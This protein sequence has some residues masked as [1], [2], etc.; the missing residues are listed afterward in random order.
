MEGALF[1]TGKNDWET[2]QD[3]FD[4]W[5][6]LF[7]FTIDVCATEANHKCDRYYSPA[8]NGLTKDWQFEVVWCNPPYSAKEQ[9][10]WV[11]KCWEEGQ[12]SKTIVVALLPARTDT[13][14]FH[15][16]IYHQINSE[17]L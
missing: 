15:N 3:F 6:N 13:K 7:H 1:S 10:L 2:P 16:I 11:Q 17:S 12:K 8:D 4:E 5:D 14:R 9:D